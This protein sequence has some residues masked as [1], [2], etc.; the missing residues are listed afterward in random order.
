M[1]TGVFGSMGLQ[2]GVMVS[3]RKIFL[4]GYDHTPSLM[5]RGAL[6]ASAQAGAPQSVMGAGFGEAALASVFK[7]KEHLI[8]LWE[9][10]NVAS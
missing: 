8:F 2:S 1:E 5:E 6:A 7:G 9:F 10:C 4:V 3:S